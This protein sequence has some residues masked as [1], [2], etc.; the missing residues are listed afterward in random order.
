MVPIAGEICADS[1]ECRDHDAQKRFSCA[2]R[3]AENDRLP[4]VEKPVAW[5]P[6]GVR[7]AARERNRAER[8]DKEN[9]LYPEGD[10][11]EDASGQ[12]IQEKSLE[13]EENR[14]GEA[15]GGG[16]GNECGRNKDQCARVFLAGA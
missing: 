2:F 4:E 9:A 10:R 1:D 15:A 14:K 6:F 7:L 16:H 8:R 5:P 12:Q 11:A 3:I 13:G